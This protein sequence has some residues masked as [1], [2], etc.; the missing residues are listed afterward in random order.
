MLLCSWLSNIMGFGEL[1]CELIALG[2][3]VGT[4]VVWNSFNLVMTIQKQRKTTSVQTTSLIIISISISN[5][6]LVLSCFVIMVS[7]TLNPMILCNM[8]TKPQYLTMLYLWLSSN[9]M[10]FWSIAW[11]SVFYCVKVVNFSSECFRVL[12]RNI[13]FI[14]N[15]ALVLSC[16]GSFL[17][18]F[19]FFT[20]Y[21]PGS[22]PVTRMAYG[23]NNTS[24][25]TNATYFTCNIPIFAPPIDTDIYS[26]TFLCFLCPLP[27]MI[28]LPASIRMVVYLCQHVLTLRKN[29]TQVQSLDSYLTV[30]KIT[31]SLVGVYLTTLIIVAFFFIFKLLML[32]VS[33]LLIIFGFS[34]Y[35]IMTAVLLTASETYLKKKF[36]RLCCFKKFLGQIHTTRQP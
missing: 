10:S 28:M 36:W 24:N 31:V 20:L 26:M 18:F 27:L 7:I 30:C 19:P 35:C 29:Q 5:I 33:F 12:K 11:L 6:T 3:M 8:I 14:T 17:L 34:F 25:T 32:N 1:I 4:G 23:I 21:T 15:S 9:C 22:E 2:V 16:L 13:S